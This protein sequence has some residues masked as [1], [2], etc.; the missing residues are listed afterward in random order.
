[1]IGTLTQRLKKPPEWFES[2][3]D[4]TDTFMEGKK[5]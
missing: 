4:F 1:M 5:S 2:Q 3:K